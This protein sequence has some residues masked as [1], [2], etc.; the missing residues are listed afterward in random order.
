[1][2]DPMTQKDINSLEA[3]LIEILDEVDMLFSGDLEPEL[4]FQVKGAGD[5]LIKRYETLL[6]GLEGEDKLSVQRRFG[7]KMEKMKGLLSR[8]TPFS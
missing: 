2:I 3:E 7:L 6:K 1:M 4:A 5:E 8:I